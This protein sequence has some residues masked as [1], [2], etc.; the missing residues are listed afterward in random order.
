[1]KKVSIVTNV[2]IILSLIVLSV[3]TTTFSTSYVFSYDND[4]VIYNGDR[5]DNKV[6]IMINVYEGTD[7]INEMLDILNRYNAKAT[8][9][10]GGIWAEK[11]METLSK[12]MANGH[13]VGNHGYLHLDH[14]NMDYSQNYDEILMC[15]NLIKVYTGHDM[16]LFA[17]PSGAFNN[18]TVDA[19]N[20][21]G[22]ITIMWSKDTIDWRDHDVKLIYERATK[23]VSGGDFILMHPTECSVSALSA[24]LEYY[25]INNLVATT[26]SDNL[27][28][29]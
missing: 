6:S 24:I 21:L 26:V 9:F 1:M 12:I 10:I 19:C 23:S 29:K 11:N 8:F 3:F 25:R 5:N 28:T 16:R 14:S 7:H 15:H 20:N 18:A 13:E 27:H 2:I 4:N 17:P 22:Y